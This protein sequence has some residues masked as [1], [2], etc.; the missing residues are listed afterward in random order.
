MKEPWA[1]A[2]RRAQ[3]WTQTVQKYVGAAPQSCIREFTL[4]RDGRRY[5][6]VSHHRGPLELYRIE[7]SGLE[8]FVGYAQELLGKVGDR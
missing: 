7:D 2:W 1:V 3:Q 5:K 8:M 4:I 6:T